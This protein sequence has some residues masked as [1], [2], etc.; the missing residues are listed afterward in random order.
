MVLFPWVLA[1]LAVGA[2]AGFFAGMLG[3]GGGLVMVP[4]LAMIFAAQGGFPPGEIL[5]MALGTSM[6]AIIFTA[7]ASLKTHHQHGAVLWRVVAIITP[8]I[9]L[10]T[11][12]AES[13][14]L[15][16]RQKMALAA[17]RLEAMMD[18]L[19]EES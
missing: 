13:E 17:E 10:G 4:L 19:P 7:I 14:R 9:L 6:A 1:Y 3:I 8:G 12:A 11:A 2:F 15:D 16:L 5:H 18:K